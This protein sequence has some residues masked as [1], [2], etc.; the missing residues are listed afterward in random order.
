MCGFVQDLKP[1]GVRRMGRHG[2]YCARPKKTLVFGSPVGECDH[3]V[4]LITTPRGVKY[5]YM[6]LEGTTHRRRTRSGLPALLRAWTIA[7]GPL[8]TYVRRWP[9]ISASSRTPPSDILWNGRS[10]ALATDCAMDVLPQ[11]GGPTSLWHT[12]KWESRGSVRTT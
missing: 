10:N 4:N 11:P 2:N 12:C 7:P 6:I 9:L 5:V 8:A 1:Q 3:L